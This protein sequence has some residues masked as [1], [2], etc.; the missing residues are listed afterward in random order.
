MS[1]LWHLFLSLV[2]AT[3]PPTET[4]THMGPV[5]VGSPLPSFRGWLLNDEPYGYREL[6]PETRE[7]QEQVVLISYYATWCAPCKTGMPIIERVIV[8]NP[9]VSGLFISID[10]RKDEARLRKEASLFQT[11]ILWDKYQS[12][13]MRHGVV[14][15]ENQARIPRTLVMDGKGMVIQIYAT[16]GE[17]FEQALQQA[18][19]QILKPEKSASETNT[20]SQYPVEPSESTVPD[21]KPE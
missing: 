2:F 3:V 4:L 14:D 18:V 1:L 10:S 16:E 12:V 8:E 15:K 6:F 9:K 11:P 5:S 19:A 21:G 7:A 13:A 20:D 17:D